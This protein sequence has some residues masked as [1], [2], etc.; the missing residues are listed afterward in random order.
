VVDQFRQRRNVRVRAVDGV[1]QNGLILG[2]GFA[3]HF[4]PHQFAARNLPLLQRNRQINVGIL[5]NMTDREIAL[6]INSTNERVKIRLLPSAA[7]N[8]SACP[9]PRTSSWRVEML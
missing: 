2:Y 6:R 5:Q 4:A 9:A 1:D 3:D 7:A 8:A